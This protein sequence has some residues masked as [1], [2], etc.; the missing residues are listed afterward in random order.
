VFDWVKQG[1]RYLNDPETDRIWPGYASAAPGQRPPSL[2]DPATGKLA[3]PWLRPHLGMRPPFAPNHGPAP[4]LEP[5]Q[6]GTA[7]A[8]PGANGPWSICPTGTKAKLFTVHAIQLPITLNPLTRQIDPVG[9]LFVLRDQEEVVR[10]SNDLKLPLAIRANA[11][12]DCVDLILKSEL[13]DSRDNGFLS[14]VNVHIHFTQFDVQ[15]SDGVNTGFNY[16]Q[17]VRPYAVEGEK[18]AVAAAAGTTRLLLGKA[19]RFQAGAVVGVGMEQNATF[20]TARIAAVSGDTLTLDAPLQFAHGADEI[21]STEFVRYRWYPD[22]QFGT[23]YF[24]DHVDALHSWAHGLFGA[25]VAE[26]PGSTYHDPRSGAAVESGP[27][28]DVHTLGRVSADV[29]GS[30]RELVSFLQDGNPRTQINLSSGSTFNLRAEPPARRGGDPA[31]FFSSRAHGDPATPIVEALVGDPI[32]FRSLV[33]GTN[34]VHTFHVDGHWFRADPHSPTSPPI[35][36]AHLGI[37]ER[38]DLVVPRAGGPAGYPGDYLYYGGRAS[39]LQEGSWGILRILGQA[40]GG[41]QPLPGRDAAPPPSALCPPDAPRKRFAVDALHVPLPML[42]GQPGLI[43]ALAGD[44][45]ATLS[46]DRPPE[47][48]VLRV[49]VGDCIEIDLQNETTGPVSFHAG[50]LAADPADSGGVNAGNNPLQTVAPGETRRST[51]YASPEVGETTAL[52]RDWGNVLANPRLGLYGAIVVGPA[53]ATYTDPATGADLAEAASWQADVHPPNAAPYRD[54]AL[55]LEDEDQVLGTAQMPY[56]TAVGGVA[57]VNYR[58]EPLAPRLARDRDPS[59]RYMSALHGDP[60]TPLLQAFVGDAVRLHVLAPASEQG[61]VL[62]VEGHRYRWPADV[63]RAGAPLRAS[64]QIG[65]LEAVTVVLDGG[66]GGPEGLPGDYLYG[67]HREP[68]REAGLWGM[69]RVYPTGAA[70]P[71]RPLTP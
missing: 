31:D 46:G 22:V 29:V 19:D 7:P 14:K 58:A 66:A 4:F 25:L 51:L 13:Q 20:E 21:V 69:F 57:A 40:T 60:A 6:P 9:Q 62:S 23:A 17:S 10:A 39:K 68:Y 27:I 35:D 61:H 53:G 36:T 32:V 50:M 52:V 34:E 3:Y 42:G 45:D 67:D 28:V 43:Y 54:F 18:L 11:G 37:S 64:Q 56:T 70:G 44:R 2:F 15:A 65:A 1:A 55:F 5:I 33:A 49:G 8:A 38:Y 41:L 30:F 16:E 59:H 71:I 26:P 63:G 48:L 47:P 24:H 12:E